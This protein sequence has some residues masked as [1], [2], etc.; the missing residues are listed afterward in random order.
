VGV[1]TRQTFG[2]ERYEI[3]T[4]QSSWH[5]VPEVDAVP[6]S[7]GHQYAGRLVQGVLAPGAA[8]LSLDLA[9]AYPADSG[10]SSWR[11]TIRLDRGSSDGGKVVIKDAWNISHPPERIVLH[12]ITARPPLPAAVPGRL[13]IPAPDSTDPGAGKDGA[14]GLAIDYPQADFDAHIEE[15]PVDDPQLA[16]T[17]GP[18]IYRI[19]LAATQPA[20]QGAAYLEISAVTTLIS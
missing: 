11:R 15:H 7:A 14:V 20:S 10:I 2:P 17:W 6:Q 16:V 3:W 9:R 1:Y 18:N 5:N 8:E 4:M 13:V 12:L 19:T